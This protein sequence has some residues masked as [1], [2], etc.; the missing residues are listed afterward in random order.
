MFEGG[1]AEHAGR[2]RA[3][4]NEMRRYEKDIFINIGLPEMKRLR[5]I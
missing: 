1:M 3:N 2:L 5:G 4:V